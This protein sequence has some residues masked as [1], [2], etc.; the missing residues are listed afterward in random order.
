MSSDNK[1]TIDFLLE[2]AD[3]SICLRVYTVKR[4]KILLNF[5]RIEGEVHENDRNY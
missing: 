3:P 1:K 5:D 4:A 2:N